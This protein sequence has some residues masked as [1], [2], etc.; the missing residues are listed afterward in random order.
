MGPGELRQAI[1]EPA[2]AEGLALEPGLVE[3]LLRDLGAVG[4]TGTS[5]AATLPLLSHALRATWQQRPD[6]TLTVAGYARTGG[7][8]EAVA[9]TAER[10]HGQLPPEHQDIARMLLLNL[11]HVGDAG[12]DTRNRTARDDLIELTT[13]GVPSTR[14]QD[15]TADVEA[16]T[17]ARLLTA[18][19]DHVETGHEALQ[20]AWPRLR[21]WIDGPRA[22][23]RLHQ[24]LTEAARIWHV[25]GRDTSLL[26][27]GARLATVSDW[28]GEETGAHP[29]LR[30]VEREFLR[31]CRTYEEAERR[32][33]RRLWQLVAGLAVLLVIAL[34]SG[35]LVVEKSGEAQRGTAEAQKQEHRALAA[36][37]SSEAR[38]PGVRRRTDG[39]VRQGS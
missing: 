8:H 22:R 24:R 2:A 23:L 16:F 30:P 32:R 20:W 9:A 34:T 13:A 7:V 26:L 14:A 37:L 4:G 11:V 1:T 25:E 38:R 17:G 15:V 39:S 28:L 29:V 5:E 36:L 12:D 31:A 21:E 6:D 19:A 27:C 10:V 35:L 18:H 33:S 3:V